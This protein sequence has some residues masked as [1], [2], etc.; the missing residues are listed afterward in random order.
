MFEAVDDV[1]QQ[2]RRAWD[3][4]AI[5]N[6]VSR[7]AHAQDNFDR[8]A[9]L[10][11]FADKVLL[12][13]S[14]VFP[15]WTPKE[16]EATELLDMYFETMSGYDGA[17]HIVTNHLIDVDGDEAT[18]IADLYCVCWMSENGVQKDFTIGGRY[19]LRLRRIAGQWR[20]WERSIKT[21]YLLGDTTMPERA[22][23]RVAARKRTPAEA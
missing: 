7:V 13:D 14:V 16:L 17:H 20:I 10:G 15:N 21:R 8:E 3:E 23:A 22:A 5:V 6:T 11:C 12:T 9:Y 19:F 2:A 18:C 1:A 4:V